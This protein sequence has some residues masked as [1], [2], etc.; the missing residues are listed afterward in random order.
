MFGSLLGHKYY[1]CCHGNVAVISPLCWCTAYVAVS[2]IKYWKC[3]YMLFYLLASL[4]LTFSYMMFSLLISLVLFGHPTF[5]NILFC[6]VSLYFLN[7]Y[8]VFHVKCP[9]FVYNF[10]KA[11][12]L[13]T[14]FNKNFQYQIS[15]TSVHL[16]PKGY[17]HLGRQMNGRTDTTNTV[18]TSCKF[19]N[20]SIEELYFSINADLTVVCPDFV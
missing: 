12:I 14:D 16:E 6:L 18:G 3:F 5:L 17:T 2:N 8:L 13:L 20:A 15:C 9:V 1:K 7:T 4:K 10:N 19:T 11:W